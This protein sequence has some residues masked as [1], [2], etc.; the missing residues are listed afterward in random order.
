MTTGNNDSLIIRRNNSNAKNLSEIFVKKASSK[1]ILS[2]LGAT[3]Y[4][5]IMS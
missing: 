4:E 5:L 2:E 3:N 1:G